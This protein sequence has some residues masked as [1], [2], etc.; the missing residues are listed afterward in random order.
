MAIE[1]YILLGNKLYSI[2]KEKS[3]TM[4]YLYF[5]SYL[6]TYFIYYN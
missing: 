5:L 4:Y 2:I 1:L 3:A 6:N